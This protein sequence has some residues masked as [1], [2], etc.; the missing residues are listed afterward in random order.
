MEAIDWALP[1]TL[2]C[3]TVDVEWAHPAVVADMVERL[4]ERGLRGTFFC[5]HAGISVPGHERGLHPNFRRAGDTLRLLR[6]RAGP[7]WVDWTDEAVHRHV[8]Q[9][10]LDFCPEAIGTRSHSLFY[11]SSLMRLYRE[12][13]LRYE[14]NAFLPF[15]AH[16]APVWRRHE[17]LGLPVYYID[18]FDLAAQVSGLRREA[19]R[20]A[21]PGLKVLAF[22]PNLVYINAATEAQY[23]RTKAFYHDPDWLRRHR[24]RGRGVRTLWLETLDYLAA[25]RVPTCTLAEVDAAWRAAVPA[26]TRAAS[27]IAQPC[28]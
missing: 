11:D 4:D 5:T 21:E 20:L 2:V 1:A 3:V 9:A 17:I 14:S 12:A 23:E 25:C 7:A 22:H 16:L 18:H 26:A 28:A 24:R 15:T 10:T 27:D 6:E 8:I 19:L 13:G